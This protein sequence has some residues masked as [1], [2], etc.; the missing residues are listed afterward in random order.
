MNLLDGTV[1]VGASFV[2]Y[3]HHHCASFGC[4]F[5]VL[6]WVNNHEVNIQWFGAKFCYGFQYW[7]A[8]GDVRYE[9]P[10]HNVHMEPICFTLINHFYIAL[11]VNEIGREE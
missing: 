2:V 5:D 4:L 3:V 1:Q 8:K 9:D 6:F 7:E 11:Q 10:V